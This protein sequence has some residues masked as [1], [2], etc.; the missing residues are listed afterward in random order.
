M[1]DPKSASKEQLDKLRKQFVANTQGGPWFSRSYLQPWQIG[2]YRP[3]QR[4]VSK[5]ALKVLWE[6]ACVNLFKF[7]LYHCIELLMGGPHCAT[8]TREIKFWNA[9]WTQHAVK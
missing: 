9:E 3:V 4:R 1:F 6:G 8:W 7:H 2:I 5:D